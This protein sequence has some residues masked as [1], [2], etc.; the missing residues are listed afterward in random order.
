MSTK[1]KNKK[2]QL[3][4]GDLIPGDVFRYVG[5]NLYHLRVQD[6]YGGA[7]EVACLISGKLYSA[8]SYAAPVVRQR[9]IEKLLML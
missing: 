7:L 3:T 5:C 4:F 9:K 8:H 1:K 2:Q 6:T